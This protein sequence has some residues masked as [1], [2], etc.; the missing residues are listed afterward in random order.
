MSE[1]LNITSYDYSKLDE[2][3]K[4]QL[5]ILVNTTLSSSKLLNKTI[6]E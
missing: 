5:G 1:L 6:G 3:T 4:Y 2:N